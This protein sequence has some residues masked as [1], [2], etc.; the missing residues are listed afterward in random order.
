MQNANEI[1]WDPAAGKLDAA[2]LKGITAV[3]HLA[4]ANVA[5]G[6]WTQQRRALIRDSR[7]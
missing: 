5:G 7:I 1:E 6:R 2:Q 3:I 4:G